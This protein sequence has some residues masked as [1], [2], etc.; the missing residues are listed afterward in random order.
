M[1]E[2]VPGAG[3]EEVA[4]RDEG[5]VF[6]DVFEI[7]WVLDDNAWWERRDGNFVCGRSE[8]LLLL[9]EPCE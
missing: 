7:A 9:K 3:A 6:E 4:L 5:L 8:A 2:Q 1:A